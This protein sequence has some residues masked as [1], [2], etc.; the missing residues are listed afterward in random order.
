MT[1]ILHHL[2]NSRSQRII[3]L[4]EE[5]ELQ[6]EVKKYERHP[7]TFLAQDDLKKLHPLGKSPVITDDGLT[8]AES[9]AIIEYL[10]SKYGNGCL[11]P[12]DQK[13]WVQYLFWLHHAE[14]SA[15]LYM[16]ERFH[17]R[18]M[19]TP[20]VQEKMISSFLQPAQQKELDFV[21]GE[22]SKSEY[23]AGDT[24]SACDIQMAFVLEFAEVLEKS[25]AP[26]RPKIAAYMERVRSRPAYKRAI[27]KGDMRYELSDF[28]KRFY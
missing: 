25:F 20:E 4:L 15:M 19:A 9:G 16:L 13:E 26:K 22:L 7:E 21:E 14:G 27:E 3:W 28:S 11:K 17:L 8:I 12:K 2:N 24:F 10:V 6:Y 18:N 23:L 1:V 5:L